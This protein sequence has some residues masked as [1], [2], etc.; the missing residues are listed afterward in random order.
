MGNN[1]ILIEIG[2]QKHSQTNNL[3]HIELKTQ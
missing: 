1:V 3:K 2:L